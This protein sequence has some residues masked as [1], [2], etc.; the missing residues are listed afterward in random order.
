MPEITAPPCRPGLIGGHDQDTRDG[1]HRRGGRPAFRPGRP[2]PPLRALFGAV[3]EQA[4]VLALCGDLTDTG[5]ARRGPRAC[6]RAGDGQRSPSSPCSA[7]TTTSPTRWPRSAGYSAT[8]ACSVLD[9]RSC[10]IVG[11]GFAGVKGF[12]GGFGRGHAR[13]RGVRRSSRRSCRR[14]WTRRSSWR[15]PWRGCGPSGAWPCCTT[16][17]SRGRWRAS[18]RRSIPY[19]GSS[20]L[21]EPLS[22]YPVDAVFHGHAH[23]GTP[24][25]QDQD[26]RAGLQRLDQPAPAARSRRRAVPRARAAV[27]GGPLD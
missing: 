19:L 16:R 15:R 10:E 13:V 23:H 5:R 2:G 6:P 11:V 3:A 24:Q 22:R 17:P 12:A 8:R 26:G 14:R 9:G 27:N 18:R 25:G 20:R 21:E 4:D 1:P 7:I